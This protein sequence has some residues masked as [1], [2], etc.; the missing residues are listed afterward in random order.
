MRL[1]GVINPH[2]KQIDG[3]PENTILF[4]GTPKEQN[5]YL[6]PTVYG[7]RIR[8]KCPFAET[9]LIGIEGG[10]ENGVGRGKKKLKVALVKV[11]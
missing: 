1:C 5:G 9:I 8:G 3:F 6:I 2:R 7:C 4:S 10:Q 11:N